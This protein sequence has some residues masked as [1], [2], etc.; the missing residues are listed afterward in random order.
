MNKSKKIFNDDDLYNKFR[1]N[2]NKNEDKKVS[3]NNNSNIFNYYIL[4]NFYRKEEGKNGNSSEDINLN[5]K[6]QSYIPVIIRFKPH[7]NNQ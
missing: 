2:Q 4:K 3:N 1:K 5:M 7:E 6:N